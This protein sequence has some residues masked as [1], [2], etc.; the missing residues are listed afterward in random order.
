MQPPFPQPGQ[1]LPDPNDATWSRFGRRG[2]LTL[3]GGSLASCASRGDSFTDLDNLPSGTLTHINPQTQRVVPYNPSMRV[4]S[5]FSVDNADRTYRQ[6]LAPG[7]FVAMTFDDGPHPENT[8]RLLNILRERNIKATFFVIGRSVEAYPHVVRRTVE[9]GHEIGNHTQTH[10]LL[11]SLGTSS[12]LWEMDACI[13]SVRNAA[14]V[15]MR[16]MRPPYGGL[17]Q[18]QRQVVHQQFGYPTI[19]WSVDPL[20]W[21][22]RVPSIVSSRIIQD[23]HPGAIILAHD[24]HATTVAAMPY[25]L[26]TLL[27]QG[28]RF[29]TVSQLLA[30]HNHL[31]SRARLNPS[32]S[33]S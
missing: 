23:T 11:T 10:R 6:T 1:P 28:Y 8:P 32:V 33:N 15:D 16:V 5:N 13:R 25:A 17:T 27:Y 21:K 19:L 31:A 26:D 24:L 18:Y 2:F 4:S 12:L 14:G 22:N 30:I 3:L 20:D 7:K 29:V 9:E